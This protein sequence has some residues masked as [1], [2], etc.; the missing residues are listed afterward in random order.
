[1]IWHLSLLTGPGAGGGVHGQ[2]DVEAPDLATAREVFYHFCRDTQANAVAPGDFPPGIRLVCLS[3]GVLRDDIRVDGHT[4]EEQWPVGAR[5]RY[6]GNDLPL[7]VREWRVQ[8][9]TREGLVI[10]GHPDNADE[11]GADWHVKPDRLVYA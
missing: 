5:V 6:T 4:L 9:A 2:F 8:G 7:G 3:F 1:M 10:L 11:D